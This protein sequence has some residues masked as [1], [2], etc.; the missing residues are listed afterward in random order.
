MVA[1]QHVLTIREL[2]KLLEGHEATRAPAAPCASVLLHDGALLR[3]AIED[4]DIGESGGSSI[5]IV[6]TIHLRDGDLEVVVAT[7]RDVGKL[8]RYGAGLAVETVD[9]GLHVEV[10][11]AGD[12]AGKHV[13]DVE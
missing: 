3:H 2:C 12:S 1:Q 13:V 11:R 10:L 6:D 9:G 7:R 5:G 8:Q 4:D